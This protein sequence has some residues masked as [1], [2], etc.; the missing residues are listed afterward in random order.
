MPLEFR[1]NF[2]PPYEPI[3]RIW[4]NGNDPIGHHPIAVVDVDLPEIHDI[5]LL[6]RYLT[7]PLTASATYAQNVPPLTA[8]PLAF[9]KKFALL[10]PSGGR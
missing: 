6:S 3:A 8:V 9:E 4:R 1:D 10:I 7:V 2:Y 5:G